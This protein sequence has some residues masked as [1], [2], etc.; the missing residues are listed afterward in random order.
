MA[1]LLKAGTDKTVNRV[2]YKNGAA[3]L[4]E[5]V[6][7]YLKNGLGQ[8]RELFRQLFVPGIDLVLDT[9]GD[10]HEILVCSNTY[11]FSYFNNYYASNPPICCFDANLT[12]I[13]G[14]SL[15]A[16]SS[17][18]FAA[19]ASVGTYSLFAGG[20]VANSTAIVPTG[21]VYA[22]SDSLVRTNPTALST[23]RGAPAGAAVGNYALFAGGDSSTTGTM[24]ASAVVNAY[25]ASMV[26]STP[27]ALSVARIALGGISNGTY[28]LFVGGSN[29]SGANV[30][31]VEAYNASL[32]RT[33][34]SSMTS[35][36]SGN[37]MC[38]NAAIADY[39]LIYNGNS[40]FEVYS[41]ALVKQSFITV[42]PNYGISGCHTFDRS[43]AVFLGYDS[44]SSKKAIGFAYDNT[45]VRSSVLT[46]AL[47]VVGCGAIGF[48]DHV[49]FAKGSYAVGNTFATIPHAQTLRYYK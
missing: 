14:L 49:V 31:T 3:G 13:G 43:C 44:Y 47:P 24:A 27:T 38:A 40:G 2:R 45:L 15:N 11:L 4:A 32:T 18:Y 21:A 42:S 33:T 26:R 17:P 46:P 19:A 23:A 10:M 9:R 6:R 1:V 48:K 41:K 5:V 12:S 35:N 16:A 36:G 29:S 25:S 20:Y 39:F 28:A 30:T 7:I 22:F 34:L 37:Y 8:L